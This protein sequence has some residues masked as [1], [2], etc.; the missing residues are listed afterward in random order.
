MKPTTMI[1]LGLAAIA[2]F[3]VLI[4]ILVSTLGE[5]D[6]SKTESQAES[7]PAEPAAPAAEPVKPEPT[8]PATP[9]PDTTTPA[10]AT[11]VSAT[12][13]GRFLAVPDDGTKLWIPPGAGSPADLRYVPPGS[14]F[15]LIARPAELLA[16][17]EGPRV[18]QALGPAMALRD[19]VGRRPPGC[20]W[21]PSR[22]SC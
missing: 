16:G 4:L 14:Q 21:P 18:I 12:P 17:S 3:L 1:G 6:R 19:S 10:G 2:A 5:G 8:P 20:R 15:Y 7:E 9:K 22:A 13:A 11:P